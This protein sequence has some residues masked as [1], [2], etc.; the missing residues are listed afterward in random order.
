MLENKS[1]RFFLLMV[2][3]GVIGTLFTL[4]SY[5]YRI[6]VGQNIT[7]WELYPG[8][9]FYFLFWG[10]CTPLIVRLSRHFR[11]HKS[12]WR[13]NIILQVL[14]GLLFAVGQRIVYEFIMQNIRATAERPFTWERLTQNVIGFSDYGLFIYIIIV[15]IDHAKGYYKELIEEQLHA[16]R[17]KEELTAAQLQALKMQI[18]PHF[19][20][21]SLNTVSVLIQEEP[22]KAEQTLIMISDLLRLTLKRSESP[23]IALKD[24]LQYVE[25]Y[26][27]IEQVRFGDRLKIS[28]HSEKDTLE[29]QVP[30]L[31][32]QPLVE[33]AIKH[34]ISQKRGEG[35]IEI[36]CER[37]NGSLSMRV[38]DNGNGITTMGNTTEGGI[39]LSNTTSRLK[40]LYG[41]NANIVLSGGDSGGTTIE[42]VLPLKI[43]HNRIG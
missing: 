13:K 20:F 34:G 35:I 43:Q 7:W 12:N 16:T 29:A 18:H 33:N 26:L 41:N 28:I 19:L 39:G 24:E 23:E 40:A 9:V 17:L 22:K 38:T 31:I 15:F 10:G 25:L 5:I 1:V 14:I 32:L 3:W 6:N 2:G 27:N 36:Y 4:Q 30:P 37:K 42:I 8:E 11:V 21:N